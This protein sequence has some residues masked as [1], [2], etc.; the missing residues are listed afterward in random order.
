VFVL[1][2]GER[3]GA[4]VE[5]FELLDNCF[6]HTLVELRCDA[7]LPLDISPL[8]VGVVVELDP[9]AGVDQGEEA[10]ALEL[11]E[12]F[13]VETLH[14]VRLYLVA[15]VKAGAVGLADKADCD[16]GGH[17]PVHLVVPAALALA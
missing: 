14:D 16:L 1:V 15:V 10:I 17:G 12:S 11:A 13:A 5:L 8:G 4:G 9:R 6:P 3:A 2:L 7:V